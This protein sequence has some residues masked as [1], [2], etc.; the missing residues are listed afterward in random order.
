MAGSDRPKATADPA[1]CSRTHGRMRAGK[2]EQAWD[3]R[4]RTAKDVQECRIPSSHSS[5]KRDRLHQHVKCSTRTDRHCRAVGRP[6]RRGHTRRRGACA[7]RAS[8][9]ADC[10]IPAI[11]ESSHGATR[12]EAYP[13]NGSHAYLKDL[14]A[15]DEGVARQA[16]LERPPSASPTMRAIRADTDS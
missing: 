12:I 6:R 4:E 9:A 5:E 7:E 13:A 10:G 8:R 15:H 2:K 11:S 1:L 16:L 14:A 3:A